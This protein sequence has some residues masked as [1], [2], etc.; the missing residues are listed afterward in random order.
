MTGQPKTDR[1]REALRTIVFH[2]GTTE[3]VSKAMDDVKTAGW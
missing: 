3:E 1:I 2:E